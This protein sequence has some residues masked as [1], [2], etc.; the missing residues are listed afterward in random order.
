MSQANSQATTTTTW[1]TTS[2]NSVTSSTEG[3]NAN[4]GQA[5][6]ATT[7]SAI[8]GAQQQ[9]QQQQQQMT[10]ANFQLPNGQVVQGQISQIV[11]AG[12]AAAAW[13]PG[14]PLNVQGLAGLRPANVIQVQGLPVAG[15][16]GVQVQGGQA[17]Q[18]IA[19]A[20]TLQS[21]GLS[22]NVL[23]ASAVSSTPNHQQ[24]IPPLSPI[25]AVHTGAQIISK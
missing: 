22:P 14:G 16:Q 13:W 18:I 23:A 11:G 1:T 12:G 4:Q 25:Q 7:A 15:L 21:L 19:N 5:A 8:N 3:S 24:Q 6:T 20:Q 10:V 9:Q 17:Q 2:G